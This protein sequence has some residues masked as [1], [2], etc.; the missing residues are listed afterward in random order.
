MRQVVE[1][2]EPTAQNNYTWYRLYDDGW[3]EQGGIVR[4]NVMTSF[5]IQMADTNYIAT[6]TARIASGITQAMATL[7]TD[8][9]TTQIQFV[10]FQTGGV[11]VDYIIAGKSA[12]D[13][14]M[15]KECIKY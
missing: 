4:A 10:Y 6:G 15:L 9:T 8:R 7:V 2:Q 13:P 5:P 3:V 11:D 1:I 14:I 12:R